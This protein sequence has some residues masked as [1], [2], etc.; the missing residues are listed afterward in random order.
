M[1]MVKR[2]SAYLIV[3]S[4]ALLATAFLPFK[5]FA[6]GDAQTMMAFGG[7]GMFVSN[8]GGVTMT[9]KTTGI[10]PFG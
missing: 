6:A 8:D 10:T 1:G 4:A 2:I 9:G 5:A 7:N 3:L